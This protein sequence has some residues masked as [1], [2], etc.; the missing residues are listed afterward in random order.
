MAYFYF[1]MNYPDPA[2]SA[3]GLTGNL[4]KQS[5]GFV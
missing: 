5:S 4:S 2:R 3:A 1:P